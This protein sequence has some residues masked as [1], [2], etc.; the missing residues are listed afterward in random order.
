MIFHA[1]DGTVFSS[2][3]YS[4]SSLGMHHLRRTSLAWETAAGL[5]VF[6]ASGIT[7]AGFGTSF[8]YQIASFLVTPAPSMILLDWHWTSLS[9]GRPLQ[10]QFA[11]DGTAAPAFYL[12]HYQQGKFLVTKFDHAT[13]QERFTIGSVGLGT[14][15]HSMMEVNR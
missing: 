9:Q 1:S 11:A 5:R 15:T 13:G 2:H 14:E 6:F 4:W 7:Q 3:E 8:P 10:L 12:F